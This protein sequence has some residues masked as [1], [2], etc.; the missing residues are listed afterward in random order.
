MI[1]FW[2]ADFGLW[3]AAHGVPIRSD[4]NTY[5]GCSIPIGMIHVIPNGAAGAVRNLALPMRRKTPRYAPQHQMTLVIPNGAAGAVRNLAL[6]MRRKT[7]RCAPQHQMLLVIPNGAA[8]AVRNLALPMRRKT[9]RC[10]RGAMGCSRRHWPAAGPSGTRNDMNHP[11]LRS[12]SAPRLPSLSRGR[13]YAARS[14]HHE[15]R[16]RARHHVSPQHSG[17][18]LVI[19]R[20]CGHML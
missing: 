16:E 12:P 11:V 5:A 9:P 1:P 2:L 3:I 13:V 4:G 8:G 14:L 7:P 18:L 15:R 19:S 6:P 20:P 17:L 10:A